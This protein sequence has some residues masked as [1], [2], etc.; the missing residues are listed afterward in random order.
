MRRFQG[1]HPSAHIDPK[2]VE[3]ECNT[4]LIKEVAAENNITQ[5]LATAMIKSTTDFMNFT[6]RSGNLEGIRLPYLGAFQIKVRSQQYKDFLHSLGSGMKQI[7][8]ANKKGFD[9]INENLEG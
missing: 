8:K 3:K 4:R 1:V 7:F 9:A 2:Y 5:E 6:I